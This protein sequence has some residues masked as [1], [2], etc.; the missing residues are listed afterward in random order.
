MQQ[1]KPGFKRTIDWNKC[2]PKLSTEAPNPYLDILIDPRFQG[3]NI[4]FVSSFENKEDRTVHTKSS[5]RGNKGLYIYIYIY[6]IF[7]FIFWYSINIL[8]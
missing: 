5:N 1:L 3:V 4:L 8:L 7:F 2:Q 6:F